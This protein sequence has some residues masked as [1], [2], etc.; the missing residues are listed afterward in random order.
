MHQP[1][2]EDMDEELGVY[3][4]R[5]LRFMQ[6]GSTPAQKKHRLRNA[7]SYKKRASLTQ[8]SFIMSWGGRI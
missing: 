7:L 2:W 5:W 1:I 6:G 3:A 4:M 8:C